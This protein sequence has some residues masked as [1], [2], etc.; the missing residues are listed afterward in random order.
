MENKNQSQLVTMDYD[1]LAEEY[2]Q[3]RT[4]QPEVM[5]ELLSVGK[6]RSTSKILEVGCG[7]GNYIGAIKSAAGCECWGIDPSSQMLSKAREN[8]LQIDFRFGIGERIEFQDNFFDLV[9]SVDV[10]H[11][12]QDRSGYFKEAFRTLAPDGRILTVTESGWMIRTRQPF[13]VYFP[14][15]VASDL[16]RYP[17]IPALRDAMTQAGFTDIYTNIVKFSFSRTNI[18]D[19]RDKAYSCLHLVSSDGFERGI[20]QMEQDLKTSPILWISRYLLLWGR[21]PSELETSH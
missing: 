8:F 13:S 4:V 14:E 19:F 12:I 6:I 16:R 7:T 10:I 9:F 1:Q 5:K 3:H 11:H 21:K 17:T 18:R 2:A 20:T 15:T